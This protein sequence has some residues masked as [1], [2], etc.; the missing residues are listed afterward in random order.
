M[1][2]TLSSTDAPVDMI[3]SFTSLSTLLMAVP[4]LPALVGQDTS[5]PIAPEQWMVE[6]GQPLADRFHTA[7]T[8]FWASACPA[9]G[10]VHQGSARDVMTR[11]LRD[12]DLAE[13]L[14][15]LE[16]RQITLEQANALQKLL[17]GGESA[18]SFIVTTEMANRIIAWPV[19]V[20]VSAADKPGSPVHGV[21]LIRPDAVI[22]RFASDRDLLRHLSLLMADTQQRQ[23]LASMLTGAEQD[24]VDAWLAEGSVL[25][26]TLRPA[27][28]NVHASR[29]AR[30]MAVQASNAFALHHDLAR[31]S[32]A[33]HILAHAEHVRGLSGLAA[34]QSKRVEQLLSRT[35]R[36][37][38]PNWLSGADESERT[39]FARRGEQQAACLARL[40]EHVEPLGSYKSFAHWY[41][42][43]E[44]RK[45][46]IGLDPAQIEIC[47]TYSFTVCGKAL[48]HGKW[49]P[50]ADLVFSDYYT[51]QGHALTHLGLAPE[52]I[53]AGLTDEQVSNIIRSNDLRIIYPQ[54]VQ[55]LFYSAPVLQSF[56]DLQNAR[57]ATSLFAA[58]LQGI[59]DARLLAVFDE[60][61]TVQDRPNQAGISAHSVV[62]DDELVLAE[63]MVLGYPDTQGDSFLLYTPNGPEGRDWVRCINIAQVRHEV[64]GWMSTAQG[65]AYLEGQ[66]PFSQRARMTQVVERLRTAAHLITPEMVAI[67]ACDSSTWRAIVNAPVLRQVECRVEAPQMLT[68]SWYTA[69][70]VEARHTLA[71]LDVEI[72]AVTQEYTHITD[73]PA[74]ADFARDSLQAW[75]DSTRSYDPTRRRIEDFRLEVKG[76]W[77]S[78]VWVAMYGVE[79]GTDVGALNVLAPLGADSFERELVA[80]LMA[81]YL[82][83]NDVPTQYTQRLQAL[84]LDTASSQRDWRETLYLRL[85]QLDMQR[86][87][88]LLSLDPL[89]RVGISLS[90]V[91]F[92]METADTLH[93]IDGGSPMPSGITQPGLYHLGI[94]GE[95]VRGV[96]VVRHLVNQ[97]LVDVLYTPSA[98]DNLWWRPLD[99]IGKAIEQGGLGPY[100]RDRVPFSHLERFDRFLEKLSNAGYS[101]EF[102]GS[103]VGPHARVKNVLGEHDALI[104]NILQDVDASTVSKAELLSA[105]IIERGLQ[106]LGV[107]A[108]PFPPARMALG[109]LQVV[110]TLYQAARSYHM[111]DNAQAAWHFLDAAVGIAGLTGLLGKPQD[112]FL[113][114][115]FKGPPPK[116]AEKMI[117][118]LSDRLVGELDSYL[119]SVTIPQ[120]SDVPTH[121]WL[122]GV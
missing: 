84:F 73:I 26:F 37:R 16:L 47:R 50:L 95:Q 71:R 3:Q 40:D 83:A 109:G 30:L 88:L 67:C 112:L 51:A 105:L 38:V 57:L 49:M 94:K 111:A 4:D 17:S 13:I 15:L 1:S 100:L 59:V 54:K 10:S 87:C 98:P 6:F 91:N 107:L 68:P 108:L 93:R 35:R 53:A 85:T 65:R 22:E 118:Q 60:L 19:D 82:Q 102:T 29:V 9:I 99:Q 52:D 101:S 120:A 96:Y 114:K 5:E 44:L 36:A 8:Q 122:K 45:Y 55:A 33:Q 89:A 80:D 41:L 48:S 28:T 103:R 110:M 31:L 61:R 78:L 69:A 11:L 62:L 7:L 113:E 46:G 121:R 116:L 24:A 66:V 117:A 104:R 58:R 115:L 86:A 20:V 77:R 76:Q 56:I 74:Y 42:R 90:T 106:V 63:V 72:Q 75:F 12:I 92:L 34:A 2:N 25:E 97:R 32:D 21:W 81:K 70:S 27:A 14:G 79:P 23:A 39:E 18:N 119:R 43:D 64:A